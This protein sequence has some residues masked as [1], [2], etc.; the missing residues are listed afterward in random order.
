MSSV[1]FSD[2]CPF[3]QQ[4]RYF[5]IF[6]FH[7]TVALPAKQYLAVSQVAR[8]TLRRHEKGLSAK[9]LKP[10]FGLFCHMRALLL[11]FCSG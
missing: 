11:D 10:D 4:F 3:R 7:D 5:L 1:V 6:F 8:R 2:L 9:D